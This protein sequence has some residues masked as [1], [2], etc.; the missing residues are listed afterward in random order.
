MGVVESVGRKVKTFK[1]GTRD[2]RAPPSPTDTRFSSGWGGNSE[3]VVAQDHAAMVADG[4]ADGEHGWVEV[5]QIM[6]KLPDDIPLEEAALLCTWREV[7]PG[8]S[9]FQLKPGTI[10]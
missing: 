3:Y 4:V 7:H 6:R 5:S 10:S 2:R 1:S 8:F 9:D